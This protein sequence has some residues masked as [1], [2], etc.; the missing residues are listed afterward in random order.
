MGI[1]SFTLIA[2]VVNFLLLV[3]L[4][5][6]FLYSRIVQAMNDRE[7]KIASRLDEAARKSAEAE[8]E[9]EL[10]RSKNREL[11]E[12]RDEMLAKIREEAEAHRARLM[13]A[14]RLET[15]EARA[16]WLE[17]LRQERRVLLQDLRQRLARQVFALARNAL[18][19]LADAD[20]EGQILK[21]FAER[22]HNLDPE[23]RKAILAE[24]RD[25]DLQVEIRTAFPVPSEAR[26]ELSQ[27][28]CGQ[29]DGDVEA[30][31]TTA[32]DLICG[33]ELRAASHR[34]VWNLDSYLKGLEDHVFEA[35]DE[36][37]KTDVTPP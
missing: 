5:K 16:E 26:A 3:W 13:E 6:R 14:V 8:R 2:Q 1:D 24:A 19:E 4:L 27:A 12:R 36:R 32:P 28:L 33:V 31:F 23:E 22:L 7:A 18:K 15:E 10:F 30:R 21:V 9:A 11:D 20:L 17:S 34:L 25:S 29:L 35:L 37:A